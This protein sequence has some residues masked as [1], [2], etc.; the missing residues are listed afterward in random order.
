MNNN[1]TNESFI[2][3]PNFIYIFLC[4]SVINLEN[5]ALSLNSDST[6][7]FSF[8]LIIVLKLSHT[9]FEKMCLFLSN[10]FFNV[11]LEKSLFFLS[12]YLEYRIILSQD[13]HSTFFYL[14]QTFLPFPANVKRGHSIQ[15]AGHTKCAFEYY[16]KKSAPCEGIF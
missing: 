8:F 3:V 4:V 6:M 16:K 13:F 14:D 1:I 15:H 12:D 9:F 11:F 7:F 2:L 10:F 5:G